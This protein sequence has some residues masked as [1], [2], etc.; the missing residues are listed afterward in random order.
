MVNKNIV[1][2][3]NKMLLFS[4]SFLRFSKY[5]SVFFVIE[6]IVNNNFKRIVLYSLKFFF[7]KKSKNDCKYK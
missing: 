5:P 6:L 1:G 3:V 4:L 2:E 7:I